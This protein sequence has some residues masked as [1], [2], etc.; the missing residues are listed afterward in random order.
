MR[1]FSDNVSLTAEFLKQRQSELL[2]NH[3]PFRNIVVDEIMRQLFSLFFFFLL[4]LIPT[5]SSY[6]HFLRPFFFRILLFILILLPSLCISSFPFSSS[7]FYFHSVPDLCLFSFLIVPVRVFYTAS[8]T[9]SSFLYNYL[10]SFLLI[11]SSSSYS[12]PFFL[13]HPCS[14]FSPSVRLYPLL[15][16]LPSPFSL[17][18]FNFPFSHHSYNGDLRTCTG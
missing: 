11:V 12:S 13:F 9:F 7:K 17:F 5:F 18:V 3:Q 8:S 16:S 6:V 4:F 1:C 15:S 14:P 10:S 2:S